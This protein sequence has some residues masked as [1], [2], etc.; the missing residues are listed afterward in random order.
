MDDIYSNNDFTR[1]DGCAN[2]AGISSPLDKGR[3]STWWWNDTVYVRTKLN[4]SEK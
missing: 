2:I 4:Q 1:L 3:S